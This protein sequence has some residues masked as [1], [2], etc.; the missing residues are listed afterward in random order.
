MYLYTYICI[1][2]GQIT[3]SGVKQS[4]KK[5]MLTDV[6]SK[7]LQE[8]LTVSLKSRMNVSYLPHQ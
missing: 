7:C 6:L 5:C 2:I 4:Y 3:E 8:L 1:S